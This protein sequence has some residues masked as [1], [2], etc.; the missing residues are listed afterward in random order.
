[1]VES[2]R[3][4]DEARENGKSGYTSTRAPSPSSHSGTLHK[5]CSWC[6]QDT[7]CTRNFTRLKDSCSQTTTCK[8]IIDK[9]GH[10]G[11]P[12][13]YSIRSKRIADIYSL[14]STAFNRNTSAE[15]SS[16]RY[17]QTCSL[18]ISLIIF[19]TNSHLPI[20]V[21]RFM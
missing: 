5:G 1:M 9:G 4:Y 7:S 2:H 14:S 8:I 15:S 6:M 10:S 19:S 20:I 11:R 18:R 16:I 13:Y 17:S 21:C 3:F 12:I